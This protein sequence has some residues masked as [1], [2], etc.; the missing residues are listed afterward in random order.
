MI[1]RPRALLIDGTAYLYRAYFARRSLIGRDGSQVNAVYGFLETLLLLLTEQRPDYAAAAFDDPTSPTFR[2]ARYP[3]YKR[4]RPPTPARLLPQFASAMVACRSMGVAPLRM[5]GFEADDL[6]ATVAR[7][8]LADNIACLVVG[9][10][11]D[12][13]QLVKPGVWLYP[14]GQRA[15]MDAAAVEARYGVPPARIPDLLALQ[16]DAVDSLPGVPGIGPRAARRLLAT[17]GPVAALWD[18]PAA[19]AAVAPRGAKDLAETLQRGREAYCLGRELA[20]LRDDVPLGVDDAA[21]RHRGVDPVAVREFCDRL[22]FD[23]LRD[24]ILADA[25]ASGGH[26]PGDTEARRG[27]KEGCR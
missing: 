24:R 15:P 4:G 6:L 7:R 23:R 11:K 22:G 8:L 14:W 13:A 21:F 9:M 17:P 10:D 18:D 25:A 19:L 20:T 2:V 3:D 1:P 12:L 5:A 27:D 16:G 26:R